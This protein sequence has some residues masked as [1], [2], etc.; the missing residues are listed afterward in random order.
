MIVKNTNEL[1][2]MVK[3]HITIIKEHCFIYG[4]KLN[5]INHQRRKD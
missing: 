1:F 4:V 3:C 2:E 5:I